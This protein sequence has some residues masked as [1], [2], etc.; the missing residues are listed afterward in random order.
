VA[1]GEEQIEHLARRL[2]GD[3]DADRIAL[4][5]VDHHA[6]SRGGGEAVHR[7]RAGDV[8]E[9][10]RDLRVV[11]GPVTLVTYVAERDARRQ[12]SGRGQR[13]DGERPCP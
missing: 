13:P 12:S 4:G 11:I 3:V 5:R 7:V 1:V 8:F 2:I 9:V 6:P 10:Q